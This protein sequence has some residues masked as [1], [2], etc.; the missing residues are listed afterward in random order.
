MNKNPLRQ[1]N[2]ITL[3]ALD[4]LQMIL[5]SKQFSGNVLLQGNSRYCR[6]E[7]HQLCR[8][9]AP[10][11][12]LWVG[13]RCSV[14]AELLLLIYLYYWQ[15]FSSASMI[16]WPNSNY[17]PYSLLNLKQHIHL[18]YVICLLTEGGVFKQFPFFTPKYGSFSFEYFSISSLFKYLES[19]M[20]CMYERS[21]YK[22]LAC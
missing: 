12:R 16:C 6:K 8:L 9:V 13:H 18:K 10:K 21:C 14:S 7:H 11:L 5:D 22:Y 1:I 20:H 17:N 3:H 4:I 15:L 2:T 19:F